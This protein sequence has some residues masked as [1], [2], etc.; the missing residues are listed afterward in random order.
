MSALESDELVCPACGGFEVEL[1]ATG[2]CIKCTVLQ[3]YC[4]SCGNVNTSPRQYECSTCRDIKWRTKYGDA[5]EA[6]QMQGFSLTAAMDQVRID[7]RA[8]R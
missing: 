5:I 8:K 6:Y 2:W 3:G 1:A 4:I 7:N